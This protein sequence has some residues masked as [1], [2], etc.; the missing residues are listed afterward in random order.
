[1]LQLS[2]LDYT[3]NRLLRLD[4]CSE[5]LTGR[6]ARYNRKD[7][8]YKPVTLLSW[9][10]PVPAYV[11]L[12]GCVVIVF[13]FTSAVW[14][15]TPVTFAKVA[16]AYGAVSSLPLMELELSIDIAQPIVLFVLW[17]AFKVC[18]GCRFVSLERD[19]TSLASHLNSLTWRRREEDVPDPEGNPANNVPNRP[20]EW[21]SQHS[22]QDSQ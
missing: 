22:Q 8:N 17:I 12:I 11:G 1:V 13:G 14:W 7:P 16:T 9:A 6:Y 21:A 2:K 4:R 10:Q 5:H 3:A 15:D 18:N 20:I 19:F